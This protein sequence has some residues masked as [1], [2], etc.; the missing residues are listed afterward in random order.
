MQEAYV[1]LEAHLG[2]FCII[3]C[4]TT[5]PFPCCLY[6]NMIHTVNFYMVSK[7]DEN[8]FLD[9]VRFFAQNPQRARN[10]VCHT[11]KWNWPQV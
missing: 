8:C 7:I 5:N 6:L 1:T 3:A 11:R 9:V 2:M 10:E 4:I